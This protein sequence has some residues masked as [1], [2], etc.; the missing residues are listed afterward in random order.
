MKNVKIILLAVGLF[1]IN[2][3]PLYPMGRGIMSFA[4]KKTSEHTPLY[5]LIKNP[6]L[7]TKERKEWIVS[8]QKD[9]KEINDRDRYM[10]GASLNLAYELKVATLD[11]CAKTTEKVYRTFMTKNTEEKLYD[12]FLAGK[13]SFKELCEKLD[14]KKRIEN[15]HANAVQEGFLVRREKEMN[16]KQ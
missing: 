10:L 3:N 2:S 6:R 16:R 15:L 13:V 1:I 4:S 9:N 7:M 11:I 12:K 8:R 14:R 5:H